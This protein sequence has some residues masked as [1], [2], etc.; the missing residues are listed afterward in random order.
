MTGD[1]TADSKVRAIGGISAK[2]RGAT[3]AQ[4][5]LVALPA[6]NYNQLIDAFVYEG[7]ELI[8]SVQVIGISNLDDAVAVSRLDRD[9]NLTD[10]IAL[11]NQV[12]QE[13]KDSPTKIHSKE[14]ADQ[15]AQVVELEPRHFSAKLLL[16]TA[17]NAQPRK[18]SASASMYYTV[19][20]F[21]TAWPT[22]SEHAKPSMHPQ[23]NSVVVQEVLHTL[24]KVRRLADP[25]V[26]P[27]VN[28]FSE[29]IKA[30]NDYESHLASATMVEERRQ[31]VQDALAKLQANRNLMEKMLYEGI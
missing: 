29:Y 11:F 25:Q 19:T 8:T 24:D 17:Q 7:P 22:L 14:I 4:C 23:M 16:M 30:L 27:F 28:A 13:L 1:V 10:A 21:R 9:V 5:T 31:G 15:L 20:A 3:E 26:V 12:Q 6:E 18:L 2:I